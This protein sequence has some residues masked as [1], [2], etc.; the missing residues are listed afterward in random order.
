MRHSP[1]PDS[2]CI[3]GRRAS[4]T[5]I[6]AGGPPPAEKGRKPLP[7]R[8]KGKPAA[9]TMPDAADFHENGNAARTPLFCGAPSQN[10][11]PFA[12]PRPPNRRRRQAPARGAGVLFSVR[13]PDAR[14]KEGA[15]PCDAALPRRGKGR[16]RCAGST[17]FA[18]AGQKRFRVGAPDLGWFMGKSIL[19]GGLPIRGAFPARRG[20]ESGQLFI[21]TAFPNCRRRQVP[22]RGADRRLLRANGT[23]RRHCRPGGLCPHPLKGSIP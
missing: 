10:R 14:G 13:H 3:G 18:P 8:E 9:G 20:T 12:P 2:F 1:P 15:V 19:W 22:A 23:G 16:C 17:L 4:N 7:S 6:H 11:R 21:Q 5:R